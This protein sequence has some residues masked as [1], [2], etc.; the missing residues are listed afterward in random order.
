MNDAVTSATKAADA[1]TSATPL[2]AGSGAYSYLDL[3]I[4]NTGGCIGE[5]CVIAILIGFAYL[6]IRGVITPIIPFAFIGSAALMALL[7]GQDV[8]YELMSGGLLFGAV[9]MAT[10]Y[11]T[12]PIS[13]AGKIVFGI[14]CGVITML[15]RVYGSLPEGVSYAILLMNIISPQIDSLFAPKPFGTER[16]LAK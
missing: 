15:I 1:V 4:G 14:G 2:V 7:C 11:T 10:D 13:T 16:R 6:L 5:T 12:S 8:L 9:Y 3:F